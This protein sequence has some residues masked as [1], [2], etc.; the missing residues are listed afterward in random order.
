IAGPWPDL[1]LT[2]G[3]RPSMAALWIKDRSAG[4]TKLVII[5]RPHRMLQRFDLIVT[6]A[7]FHLPDLP[8]ILKLGL[9]LMRVDATRIASEVDAWKD[10]FADLKR[11]LTAVLVGGPEDPFRF[12]ESTAKLLLERVADLPGGN[13]TLAIVTSRRTPPNI[14]A[15]LSDNLP[16]NAR[17]Y[18]WTT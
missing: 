1:I 3:R 8:N 13:G 6:S 9:P 12:D 17:L 16:P 2:S 11:P 15:A 4:R 14:V 7:L 10:R 5:G 18:P